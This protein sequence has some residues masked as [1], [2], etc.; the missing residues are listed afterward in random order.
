M[1]NITK[2][3][4]GKALLLLSYKWGLYVII[5]LHGFGIHLFILWFS[6]E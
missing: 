6:Y 4:S 2:N 3:M 5:E 1:Y